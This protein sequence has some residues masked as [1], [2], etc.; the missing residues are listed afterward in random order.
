[1]AGRTYSL[2]PRAVPRVE[3]RFRRIV[4]KIPVPESLPILK[5]LHD[6]EPVSMQGQPPVVWDRAE[7]F[8]VYDRWGNM[9][10]DWSSGVLVTNAGH[11]HR[12]MIEA[13]VRQAH[14]GLLH[15]YCFPNEPRAQLVRKLADLAN[16]AV[17]RIAHSS[18]PSH[19]S[20]RVFLLT[21][22]AETTENAIKLA[23]TYGRKVGGPWKIG[24]VS[25]DKA[26]H[27]R[28][29]GAQQIGGIPALKDWIVNLDP[30]FHQVPFPDGFRTTDT[31]FDLF[32][33]TLKEKGV[34]PERIAGVI[35]ETYQ[36]GGAD[37]APK[38]YMRDLAAWCH[39]HDILLMLDE[40]QAAFGRTGT[41][42]GFEH[43]GVVPDLICCGKGITS[44]LPLGAVIG[45]EDVLNLYGPGEM[46]STHSGNPVCCA[47]AL[48]SL[49][50]IEREG[51]V[52]NARVMGDLLHAELAKLQARFPK[53]VGAVHGKG[54]VAGVLM[55]KP[56]AKNPDGDLAWDIV[57]RSVEKGLL[58][59]SPVGFGGGTVKIAPP[60]CITAEAVREGAAV[61]GEAAA[62]AIR[63]AH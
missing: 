16:A 61:L 25:F 12:E 43:Y 34:G 53:Q 24:I 62:E 19:P 58:F 11:G 57:R 39:E 31:S 8:Q 1:M 17:Q 10:L 38:E 32:L 37:F 54:L 36:G 22:G 42:W 59:F 46:T 56:G 47:A 23:R 60:L 30:D 41:F 50:I 2:E 49:D 18:H 3:T 48:A 33:R 26:F 7:G 52:E 20:Y 29:L 51:L 15:S 14:H 5:T 9:W 63:A 35:T 55:V 6:C 28:T 45:R 40:V 44:S 27:G 13:I 4:T 21:T